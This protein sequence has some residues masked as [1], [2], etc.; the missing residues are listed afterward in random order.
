MQFPLAPAFSCLVGSDSGLTI[1]LGRCW[2]VVLDIERETSLME[3]AGGSRCFALGRSSGLG[4]ELRLRLQ[5]PEDTEEILLPRGGGRVKW[6]LWDKAGDLDLF[7]L[8]D[9]VWLRGGT[10]LE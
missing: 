2:R 7:T 4:L 9:G 5:L 10:G 3:V 8:P 6:L 1:K